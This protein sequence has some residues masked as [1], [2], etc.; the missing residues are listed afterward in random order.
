MRTSLPAR[1][2]RAPWRRR[3]G[4]DAGH[5]R[6]A[7]GAAVARRRVSRP[8]HR[9]LRGGRAH[10]AGALRSVATTSAAA[11]SATMRRIATRWCRSRSSGRAG[12]VSARSTTPTSSSSATRRTTSRAR[13]RWAPL[14]VA[15]ATG[16]FTVDQLR[17]TGAPIVLKDLSDTAAFLRGRGIESSGRALELRKAWGQSAATEGAERRM[18][19][20]PGSRT[21]PTRTRVATGFEDREGHRALFTSEQSRL[22]VQAVSRILLRR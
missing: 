7:A 15:V 21:Q 14:P 11:R 17:A 16:H 13:W 6:A 10:Q 12:A 8:A 22:P 3:Q 4:R 19:E 2:D 18:A 9:Q 20:A 5:P 1:R